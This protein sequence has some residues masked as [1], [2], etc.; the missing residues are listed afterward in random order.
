MLPLWTPAAK[1]LPYA[2]SEWPFI[3][4]II[5]LYESSSNKY[6]V[7]FVVVDDDVII[8]VM[9]AALVVELRVDRLGGYR[10]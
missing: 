9:W 8:T 2:R 3:I 7:Y 5:I 1:P 4:I 10:Y 6:F